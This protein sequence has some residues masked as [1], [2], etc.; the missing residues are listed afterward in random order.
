[1]SLA[2]PSALAIVVAVIVTS[3]ILARAGRPGRGGRGARSSPFP[4]PRVV[5]SIVNAAIVYY[6]SAIA[7]AIGFRMNLFNIGV[8]GQYRVAAFA[9]AVFA[10]QGWLPGPLT[11]SFASSWPWPAGG[12]WAGIAGMLKVTAACREVISTIM[13]N[14]IAT[15]LVA[16]LLRK[17]ALQVEGSNVTSTKPLPDDRRVP[18]MAA[19]SP[20]RRARSTALFLADPRRRPLLVRPRQDA[21]RLRPAGH[22]PV[23]VGGRRE[24]RQGQADGADLDGHLRRRGRARRHAAALR[25]GLRLRRHLP[26]RPRFRR[27]RHRAARPQPPRRHRLR[28]AA[29]GLPRRSSPTPCRSPPA[30]ATG[31]SSIIQ[32]V[33]VLSV[34]I[35]YEVS[36][37]PTSASSS[38]GSP[39]R[40]RARDP[41]PDGRGAGMSQLT[42]DPARAPHRP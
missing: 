38:A 12:L 4:A 14:A 40:G 34:V 22:R 19:S 41:P 13:L 5:V 36:A 35:A 6:I 31:S 33:I 17:A 1:M 18:G 24:R 27:H 23:R 30:S 29:V 2:A 37:G 15:F 11:S 20:A 9:A 28:R 7:V 39:R 8:D 26:G 32:G 10:G 42:A 3:V 16:F 25:A 21:V